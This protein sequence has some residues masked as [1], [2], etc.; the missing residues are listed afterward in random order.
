MTRK[1]KK[2]Y[3]ALSGRERSVFFIALFFLV[4]SLA[5]ESSFFIREHTRVVPTSG[6]E[7]KEG[8]IGQPTYINPILSASEPDKN[9]VRLLFSNILEIADKIEMDKTGRIWKIRLKEKIVW[10][11]GKKLTSDD[12]IFTVEKIQTPESQSPYFLSWQGVNVSRLSEL[13]LQF[14]LVSPYPFF[15]EHLKRLY[16][17]P[18]HL[19]A[20]TPSAN[21]RLSEYNLKPVGSGPYIF[22]SYEK[23]PNGFIT[24]YRLKTNPRYFGK[25]PL[26]PNIV[27]RFYST[28][29]DLVDAFN[30]GEIDG[31]TET[32]PSALSQINRPH[33]IISFSLPNYYAIFWNQGQNIALKEREVRQALSL[34]I[35]RG[36]LIK[37]VFA[38]QAAVALNPLTVV[39]LSDAK[40]YDFSYSPSEAAN[41]LAQN[42]WEIG[43]EGFR[44]KNIKN[45]PLRLEFELTVP[46]IPF[47]TATAGYLEKGWRELGVKIN[48]ISLPAEE[49]VARAIRNREYQAILFGNTLNPPKDLYAFWHSNERFYPGLNLSLY[50]NKEADGLMESLRANFNEESREKELSELKEVIA[51]DYPAAFLYSPYYL[52]ITSKELNGAT[53]GSLADPADRLGQ[54]SEWYMRTA[55]TFK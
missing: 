11:D 40:N 7:Y 46:Q 41:L 54:I 49:V 17:L 31:F 8:M 29:P 18:K 2:I 36:A 45:T 42:G 21:W 4:A 19:F 12:V 15:L 25:P 30:S 43:K 35:D 53:G 55:R 5:A 9:L 34:A 51:K 10:A 27:F 14:N 26:I 13:E 44:E 39:A 22:E 20:E 48:I 24:K 6:G 50:S 47:L 3:L 23:Q 38:G 37:L 33:N 1:A 32:I 28:A 16:I 52:F